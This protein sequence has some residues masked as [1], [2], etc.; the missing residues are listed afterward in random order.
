MASDYNKAQQIKDRIT[1]FSKQDNRVT[2]KYLKYNSGHKN[3]LVPTKAPSPVDLSA[4]VGKAQKT[5]LFITTR[6][7]KSWKIESPTLT[8]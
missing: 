4:Q 1:R 5:T 7:K 2:L 8:D 6:K 3:I